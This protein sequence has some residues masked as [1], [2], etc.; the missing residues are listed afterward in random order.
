M[1]EFPRIIMLVFKVAAFI[2]F[3]YIAIAIV[4]YFQK[5]TVMVNTGGS[6]SAMAEKLLTAPDISQ[7]SMDGAV[8][9][10]ILKK[11]ALDAS[12]NSKIPGMLLDGSYYFVETTASSGTWRFSNVDYEYRVNALARG[13]LPANES[14]VRFCARTFSTYAEASSLSPASFVPV[15]VTDGKNAMAGRATAVVD[16]DS[17]YS[18]G[19]AR[20]K[21]PLCICD[22]K[23]PAA[24]GCKCS[25]DCPTTEDVS[26]DQKC[27]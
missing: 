10:F 16:P 5:V 20:I 6:Q 12:N 25:P 4:G 19:S 9:K 11:S 3:I 22:L 18:Y 13:T 24:N 14:G 27:S 17:S 2:A 8:Q 1:I 26:K 21:Y 7:K 15:I 23:C